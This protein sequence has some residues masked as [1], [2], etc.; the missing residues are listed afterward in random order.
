VTIK[1]ISPIDRAL[2]LMVT[3]RAQAGSAFGGALRPCSHFAPMRMLARTRRGRVARDAL[4]RALGLM[5]TRRAQAGSA[6]G[7]A[8]RPCSHFASK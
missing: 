1:K 2:G 5:V 7:G 6:F 8:L 4:D 3:R